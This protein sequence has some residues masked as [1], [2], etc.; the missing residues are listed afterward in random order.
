ML[1]F[2]IGD[3]VRITSGSGSPAT[4]GFKLGTIGTVTR[5]YETNQAQPFNEH[6]RIDADGDFWF[7]Y[8]DELEAATEAK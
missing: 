1:K 8:D 6:Y 2:K 4:H 5:L 7:L 3:Q